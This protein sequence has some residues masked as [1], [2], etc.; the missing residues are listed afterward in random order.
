MACDLQIAGRQ[1]ALAGRQHFEYIDY[2]HKV[3]DDFKYRQAVDRVKT[4]YA[5]NN[6]FNVIRID[7]T[8]KNNVQYHLNLALEKKDLLYVSTFSLYQ[9]WL[10]GAFISNEEFIMVYKGYGTL[11]KS[12]D[13]FLNNFKL[14]SVS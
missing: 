3:E 4:M 8:Q 6:G 1:A 14:L 12:E 11:R 13:E 7:Y 5:I 2:F 10:L 9:G